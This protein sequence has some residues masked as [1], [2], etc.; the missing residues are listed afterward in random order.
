MAGTLILGIYPKPFID[1]TV[2]ATQLF[3][4]LNIITTT[5]SLTLPFG[6]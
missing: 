4:H 2:N 5:Q 1:W 6:G 3:N